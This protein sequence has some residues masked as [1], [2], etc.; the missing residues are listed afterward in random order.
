MEAHVK[1]ARKTSITN[2]ERRYQ[3]VSWPDLV[4]KWTPVFH[5]PSPKASA[6]LGE[7]VVFIPGDDG[8]EDAPLDSEA[9][10]S[11]PDIVGVKRSP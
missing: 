11:T 8:W 1:T 9:A 10:M 2:E 7:I 3:R 6:Q 5:K 4:A